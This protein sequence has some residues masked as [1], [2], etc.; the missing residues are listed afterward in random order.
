MVSRESRQDRKV[1][2]VSDPDH[3][4]WFS[5]AATRGAEHPHGGGEGK[6]NELRSSRTQVAPAHLRRCRGAGARHTNAQ[7]SG[8]D[9]PCVARLSVLG[10]ARLRQDEYRA[11]SGARAELRERPKRKSVQ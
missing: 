4:T 9:G 8:R 5:L 1:A 7:E 6:S 3:V 10:P 11:H 2:A